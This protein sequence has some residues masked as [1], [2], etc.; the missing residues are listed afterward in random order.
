MALTLTPRPCSSLA[1]PRVKCSTGALDPAYDV[2]RPVKAA[3]SDVTMVMSLPP[4]TTC[5]EP[6]WRMK[7]AAL[8]LM[9]CCPLVSP[10]LILA[11]ETQKGDTYANISSYSAS[12]IS[13]IGFFS[14][15]PTVL[16]TMS[17][18][19]KSFSTAANS[20]STAAAVVRSPW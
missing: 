6:A 2:Y 15:L 10:M 9:L 8:E 14:T 3:R 20:L 11:I 18:L 5:L 12:E 1:T 7:N 19:P 16:M 17:I 4:S 13:A